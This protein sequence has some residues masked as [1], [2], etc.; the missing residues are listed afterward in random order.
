MGERVTTAAIIEKDGQFLLIEKIK[1]SSIG[2]VWEFPGGKSRPGE[3]SKEAVIRE[4]LEELNL[5]IVLGELLFEHR[6]V[7]KEQEYR[8][9]VFSVSSFSGDLIL[10]DD[11]LAYQWVTKE[12]LE[13]LP[14][15]PSDRKIS[16]FILLNNR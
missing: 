2:Q 11:H 12:Q 5:T 14:M 9:D 8:M 13:S 16:S 4:C 3:S 7:N 15:S 6:F 10:S 1:T